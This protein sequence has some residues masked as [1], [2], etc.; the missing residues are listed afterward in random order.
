ME[1][2]E[3]SVINFSEFLLDNK[4]IR[5]D[6]EFQSKERKKLI[7]SLRTLGAVRFGESNPEI[8]HPN[9]I[10]RS[11]V[12]EGGVWFFRAQNN[13]PMMIDASN[14]VF[15]SNEDADSLL[16][17]QL[18]NGD[19]V[20][21]RTG[22]NAGDCALFEEEDRAIASSHTFIVRSSKWQHSYLAAFFNSN[23][24]R[25]QII[26]S[27]YGAAQPEV[28]PYYL[29]NIWIPQ[30]SARL[31]EE[32]ENRFVAARNE[33]SLASGCLMKAENLLLHSLGLDTWQPPEALSYVRSSNEVFAAG[34]LDSQ[35][36]APRVNELMKLL[37]RDGLRLH[38]AAPARHERFTPA[39]KGHFDYIEI[40]GLGADGTASAE[41]VAQAEAPSRATQFVRAGDVITST[42]RP[43]RRLSALI[44]QEQDGHVCSSGFV[45]LEPR[46]ICGEVLLTYLRLP[47]VYE[48]MDLHTSATMYPTISET[49]LMA[50]PIPAID[51]ST[52]RTIQ[53]SV[54]DA[55]RSRE[56]AN[57]LLSAAKRAVEIAIEDSETSALTYLQSAV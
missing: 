55:A 6:S 18:Q 19:V 10:N 54:R 32:I 11:Y 33:T 14:K 56:K 17:N 53:Q 25:P 16:K 31:Y 28:A 46:E 20:I 4:Y 12:E 50:L 22:A 37:G 42:V 38:D 21:T 1:G 57:N 15:I 40:G 36:F 7:A 34:R 39:D 49:D 8:T 13:R 45:V 23:F 47:L 2:L 5:L 24:G 41:A 43:I 44:A 35:Y 51:S 26:S 48:L 3:V 30:F 27:R 52:Q 9:E 29:R